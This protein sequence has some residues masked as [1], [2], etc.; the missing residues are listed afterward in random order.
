MEDHKELKITVESIRNQSI[1]NHR[2]TGFGDETQ[3]P[4][5]ELIDK[6]TEAMNRQLRWKLNKCMATIKAAQE[7]NIASH[8]ANMKTYAQ[9]RQQQINKESAT[10]GQNLADLNSQTTKAYN[11]NSVVKMNELNTFL[12]KVTTQVQAFEKIVTQSSTQP[13]SAGQT[14]LYIG[15]ANRSQG[16]RS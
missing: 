10:C 9:K 16:L 7:K 6:V 11:Q 2:L 1:Q 4:S 5:E 13:A 14:C 15:V 3:E 12:K 8:R